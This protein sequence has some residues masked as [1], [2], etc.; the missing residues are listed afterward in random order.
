MQR[1]TRPV[2]PSPR[3]PCEAC[4]LGNVKAEAASADLCG[5]R[6]ST[7]PNVL[8][9]MITSPTKPAD[10]TRVECPTCR[11]RTGRDHRHPQRPPD[12][13]RDVTLGRL[14]PD[15]HRPDWDEEMSADVVSGDL[16]AGL[17]S[18]SET[19][20]HR[21]QT[22]CRSRLDT[23]VPPGG[24]GSRITGEEAQRWLTA[25]NDVQLALGADAR[26]HRDTPPTPRPPTP[27]IW[28]SITG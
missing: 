23:Q 16:N 24:G 21:R 11:Q 18:V 17:V 27:R 7:R 5:S 28:M 3:L 15:F 10:R 14:L 19:D 2:R 26:H 13:P 4:A 8:I 12:A 25:L 1:D 22:G 6:G 20:H 9:S